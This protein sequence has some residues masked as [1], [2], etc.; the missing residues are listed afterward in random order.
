MDVTC[1]KCGR[2]GILGYF[3]EPL[4]IGTGV[5]ISGQV[6]H[7]LQTFH[8]TPFGP[9][10]DE[11]RCYLTLSELELLPGFQDFKKQLEALDAQKQKEMDEEAEESYWRDVREAEA[12]EADAQ[13]QADYERYMEANEP[14]NAPG[15]EP[16]EYEDS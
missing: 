4:N 13:A 1:P 15:E 7:V 8:Q 6:V 12:R 2:I 16:Q 14:T 11:E 9:M 5:P 10:Q 3:R